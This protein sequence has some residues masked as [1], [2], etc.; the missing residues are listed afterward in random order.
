MAAHSDLNSWLMPPVAQTEWLTLTALL[1]ELPD[2]KVPCRA[3]PAAWWPDGKGV[4]T[5]D[6]LA[7]VAACRSCAARVACLEYALA[8]DER[9]GVWGGKLPAQ[10]QR[11]PAARRLEVVA[12]KMDAA[13]R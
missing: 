10:R 12:L 6:T 1:D 9:F 11:K 2:E 3:D 8:A 4:H 13:A 5:A 7:A